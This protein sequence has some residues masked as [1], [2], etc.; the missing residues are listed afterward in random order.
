MNVLEQN[1]MKNIAKGMSEEDKIYI[2]KTISNEIIIQE[3]LRRLNT[4]TGM[5]ADITAIVNHKK[6]TEDEV[7]ES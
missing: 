1:E 4:M 3:L 5:L 6:I 7:Y 2:L